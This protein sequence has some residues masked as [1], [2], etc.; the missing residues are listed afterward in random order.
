MEGQ[1]N[2]GHSGFRVEYEVKECKHGLGLFAKQFI[3]SGTL[4]W[5]YE[6][7]VNVRTYSTQEEVIARLQELSWDER[8]FFVSHVY[9]YDGRVNEI[10]DDGMR[11]NHSESPNTG[12][13]LED[14]ESSYAIRDIQEGEELLDDY[15]TY[16]YPSWFISLAAEYEVPQ[17]FMKKKDSTRPGFHIKYELRDSKYGG[18]GLFAAEFIQRNTLIWKYA[19]GV[20]VKI[21]DDEKSV[22]RHLNKLES[23]ERKKFFLSHVYIFCGVVNE[24]LDDGQMWN[25]SD[26]PNTCSGY[27]DD[28]DSTYAAR[29]I[30]CGEELLDDYGAYEYP[31]WYLDLCAKHD[32]PQDYFTVKGGYLKGEKKDV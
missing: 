8:K 3:A 28:W 32:V 24:I 14:L 15:G 18:R 27:L 17:D 29:D 1:H 10:L 23:L 12:Q 30:Q 7:G 6:R 11:W 9:I 13:N 21:Y 16:D 25:H 4:I 2:S 20:N 31:Q 26:T 19:R 22:V 5:K